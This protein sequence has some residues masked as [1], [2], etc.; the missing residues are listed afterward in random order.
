MVPLFFHCVY[1]TMCEKN[2]QYFFVSSCSFF[3][4]LVTEDVHFIIV[5]P[6][7]TSILLGETPYRLPGSNSKFI[8]I[9]KYE[10]GLEVMNK[11]G[12]VCFNSTTCSTSRR[13]V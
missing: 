4:I 2:S 6:A 3:I 12:A 13:G 9:S 7:H 11:L 1:I 10:Q 8:L 5:V